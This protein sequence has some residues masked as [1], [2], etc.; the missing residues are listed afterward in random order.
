MVDVTRMKVLHKLW[1][2]ARLEEQMNIVK[3]ILF[4]A[5]CYIGLYDTVI[6]T[7]HKNRYIYISNTAFYMSPLIFHLHNAY[8]FQPEPVTVAIS[9]NISQ[10]TLIR[11]QKWNTF[12]FLSAQF[13]STCKQ[14][15]QLLN[16]RPLGVHARFFPSFCRWL[17]GRNPFFF[18]P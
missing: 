17:D 11:W 15:D 3:S 18:P 12:I 10:T 4:S 2:R 6:H 7:T 16:K 9:T 8:K 13:I 1:N 5:M 14:S